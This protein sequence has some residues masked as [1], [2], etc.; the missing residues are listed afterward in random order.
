MASSVV[1]KVKLI[2]RLKGWAKTTYKSDKGRE[3]STY[4][5]KKG[6]VCRSKVDALRCATNPRLAKKKRLR[7]ASTTTKSL[8][9][10]IRKKSIRNRS[11]GP[12]RLLINEEGDEVPRAPQRSAVCGIPPIG[13][14]PAGDDLPNWTIEHA[15]SKDGCIFLLYRDPDGNAIGSRGMALKMT[16][17]LEIPKHLQDTERLYQ[18]EMSRLQTDLEKPIGVI[19]ED[20]S[21]LHTKWKLGE[22]PNKY[23]EL[24]DK[25]KL[26]KRVLECDAYS[27]WIVLDL[28]CGIGGFSLG[29]RSSGLHNIIGIDMESG[30]IAA[31]RENECGYRSMPQLMRV[32]DLDIWV[33]ALTPHRERLIIIASPPCQPYSCTGNGNGNSDERDGI[34]FLFQLCQRVKP[35]AMVMENVSTIFHEKHAKV[36]ESHIS[37]LTD[38][39]FKINTE[40]VRCTD[41]EIAQKRSRAI[42][43]AILTNRKSFTPFKLNPISQT[44]QPCAGDVLDDS[45]NF[46]TGDRPQTLQVTSKLIQ[47]RFRIRPGAE[48][49]GLV[50]Y[51]A[52]SPTV[53]TTALHD[54]SYYRLV[55]VPTDVDSKNLKF[56]NLRSLTIEHIKRLQGFPDKFTLFNHIR[57]QS[58]CVGNAIPPPLA[59]AAILSTMSS[60]QH[61]KISPPEFTEQSNAHTIIESIKQQLM[62]KLPAMA[63]I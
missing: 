62:Q 59:R 19:H 13:R 63:A 35:M 41:F 34:P 5:S 30:C 43:I 11:N 9:N 49:T 44:K 14:Y 20:F 57:F 50:R 31:Y 40:I 46:W 38:V 21:T 4:T 26:A 29:A 58:H 32:Q 2:G 10:G 28:F 8:C 60:L 25:M 42:L 56:T 48:K 52:P 45:D 54:N 27:R 17:Q 3:Y 55:A 1:K 15:E 18:V 39:G 12:C 37:T 33:D 16:G 22:L 36:I 23:N 53:L 51:N 7:Q 6:L 47:S 24:F 61:V